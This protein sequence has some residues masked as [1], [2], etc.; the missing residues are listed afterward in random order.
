MASLLCVGAVNAR[1]VPC[2]PSH[3]KLLGGGSLDSDALAMTS[4]DC[5]ALQCFCWFRI[6]KRLQSATFQKLKLITS[7]W[8]MVANADNAVFRSVSV[9]L[10][11]RGPPPPPEP[12]TYHRPLIQ[13][14]RTLP[15]WR[16]RLG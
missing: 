7:S 16:E 15:W 4:S 6:F 12:E 9:F 5:M 3:L 1:Q 14:A 13:W 11:W 2:A 10:H 8:F